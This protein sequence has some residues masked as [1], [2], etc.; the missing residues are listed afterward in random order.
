MSG[1]HPPI[2]NRMNKLK[3]NLIVFLFI[4]I[5]GGVGG[6]LYQAGIFDLFKATSSSSSTMRRHY[7]EKAVEPVT[8]EEYKKKT[9]N[10]WWFGCAAGASVSIYI[11]VKQ[12][13][14]QSSRA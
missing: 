12:N 14:N 6:Y 4:T 11:I 3:E 2:Y 9:M 1:T 10:G 8:K 5:A 7:R 13:K